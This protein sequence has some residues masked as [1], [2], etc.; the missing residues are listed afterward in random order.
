MGFAPRKRE[1]HKD[2]GEEEKSDAVNRLSH[3]GSSS[4]KL[5]F[6]V[7]QHNREGG[8]RLKEIFTSDLIY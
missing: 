5:K 3:L 2:H 8:G 1:Y 4:C 6:A 7:I